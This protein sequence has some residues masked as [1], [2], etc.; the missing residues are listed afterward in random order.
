[1]DIQYGPCDTR[2]GVSSSWSYFAPFSTASPEDRVTQFCLSIDQHILNLHSHTPSTVYSTL[3]PYI[4]TS[5]VASKHNL[6]DAK[7]SGVC[8]SV[9]VNVNNYI[10]KSQSDAPDLT[11]KDHVHHPCASRLPSRTTPLF[12]PVAAGSA[13]AIGLSSLDGSI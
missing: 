3:S 11:P 6:P 7:P 9:N 2:G 5:S 1:M 10:P 8:I 12:S 13:S 4:T